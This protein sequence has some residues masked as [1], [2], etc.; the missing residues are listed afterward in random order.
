MA[1]LS[2]A[3]GVLTVDARGAMAA[4]RAHPPRAGTPTATGAVRGR[5]FA[6]FFS[7]F[8]PT[9]L[10]R[11]LAWSPSGAD[12]WRRFPS[13]LVSRSDRP[14][15]Y[16]QAHQSLDRDGAVP[17]EVT[18]SRDGRPG[19]TPLDPLLAETGTTAF[20][21][22]R[23]GE[24]L[25]ESYLAGRTRSSMARLF[26]VSK[27]V[28]ATLAGVALADGRL[29]ALDDPFV[30][31]LPELAGRGY[32]GITLRH[33]LLMAGGFRFSYGRRPWRDSPKL[34]WHPDL[35][36]VLLA[37]PPLVSGPGERFAYGSY[38]T[39]LL[40]LV[41]E[42][43]A[44]TTLAG[45]L[46][47]RL[48]RPLGAEYDASWSI[49]HAGDGLEYAA[50]GLN[51]RPIDLAKLGSLFLDRG[52]WNGAQLLTAAFADEA[53]APPE[54]ELPGHSDQ[55]R[56]DGVF[57]KFGWW[58]HRLAGG[59]AAFYAEGHR[60]QLLYVRPDRRL[61]IVRVGT[62]E[63]WLQGRWPALLRDLSERIPPRGGV[64]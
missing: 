8:S 31:Y 28:V 60:G 58:G 39:A 40:G 62:G 32:D 56:R 45:E 50:S 48:W 20:L 61:V 37:G 13:R 27:T 9:Y 1:R 55:E 4:T 10:R 29:G 51:A 19:T 53:V 43:V 57:Y 44:G 17:R 30:R 63:G 59:G 22:L 35:R 47:R 36:R 16:P 7:S 18:C 33:L 3:P 12:D 11:F 21:V 23:D 15:P 49:D 42:R 54:P 2:S 6:S 5:S 38:P 24:L 26:S 52:R 41:L 34:Y 46:E 25:R 64:G 14:S